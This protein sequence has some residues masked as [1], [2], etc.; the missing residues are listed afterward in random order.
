MQNWLPD[1]ADPELAQQVYR[2]DPT[3]IQIA[4]GFGALLLAGVVTIASVPSLREAVMTWSPK[5]EQRR[6]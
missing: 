2:S 5:F 6:G 3:S 1:D 4:W